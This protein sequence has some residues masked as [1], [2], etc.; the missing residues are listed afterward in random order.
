M[1]FPNTGVL[2]LLCPKYTSRVSPAGNRLER[3]LNCYCWAIEL[4]HGGESTGLWTHVS[5]SWV[6]AAA[7][8]AAPR[9]MYA[10]VTV[11]GE[12][13]KP[14]RIQKRV[15]QAMLYDPSQVQDLTCMEH[16]HPGKEWNKPLDITKFFSRVPLWLIESVLL[17][18][19]VLVPNGPRLK[20]SDRC[21]FKVEWPRSCGQKITWS[22]NVPYVKT[23]RNTSTNNTRIP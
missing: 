8:H 13:T 16:M 15:W 21:K 9:R 17:D 7:W 19:L 20:W 5:V 6:H 11:A 18:S 3:K 10:A 23:R 4:V 2:F 12:S 14:H 1:A 22:T